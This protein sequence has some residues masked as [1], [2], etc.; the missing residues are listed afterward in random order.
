MTLYVDWHNYKGAKS[1]KTLQL[2]YNKTVS[3]RS[4]LTKWHFFNFTAF[5]TRNIR[6]STFLWRHE[7]FVKHFNFIALFLL[8]RCL[9]RVKCLLPENR[10]LHRHLRFILLI[11]IY[12]LSFVFIFASISVVVA[13]LGFNL[14]KNLSTVIN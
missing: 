11:S 3:I 9:T 2:D 13:Y 5:L 8:S 7:S 12:M 6:K 14:F 1:Y 4:F 10:N